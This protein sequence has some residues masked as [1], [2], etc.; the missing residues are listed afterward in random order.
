[1]HARTSCSQYRSASLRRFSAGESETEESVFGSRTR[2][3]RRWTTCSSTATRSR[4][5]GSAATSRPT[6]CEAALTGRLKA[7]VDR[8]RLPCAKLDDSL[9]GVDCLQ[10]ALAVSSKQSDGLSARAVCSC[11][12][13][14]EFRS[15]FMIKT[16]RKFFSEQERYDPDCIN[17]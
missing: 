13:D 5:G 6:S 2:E 10:T 3:H 15:I 7:E 12:P 16:P 4:R 14:S 17:D 9:L 8:T 11:I 1:M